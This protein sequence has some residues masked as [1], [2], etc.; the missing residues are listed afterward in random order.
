LVSIDMN[1][2]ANWAAA[3]ARA[4]ETNNPSAAAALFTEDAV[5]Y[6]TPFEK[7]WEGRDEIVSNWSETI[8]VLQGFECRCDPIAVTG[9]T[10]VARWWAIYPSTGV[11]FSSVFVITFSKEGRAAEF[12]EWYMSR[13][14]DE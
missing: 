7:P 14:R 11:E 1:A 6:T 12:R 10:G 2:L 3:Y 5:Y 8:D 13:E 9:D 4:C